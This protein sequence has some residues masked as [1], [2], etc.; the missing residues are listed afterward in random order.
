MI[1]ELRTYQLAVGGLAEYLEVAQSMILPGV[2]EWPET[3]RVLVFRS[4]RPQSGGSSMGLQRSERASR[5]MGQV[6]ERSS[7]CRGNE[8]ITRRG[9]TPEQ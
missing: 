3:S 1:Y 9:S 2:A 7:A 6:G 5:E 4:W 8:K